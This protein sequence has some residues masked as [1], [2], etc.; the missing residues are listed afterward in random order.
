M[1]AAAGSVNTHAR[2]ISRATPQRTAEIRRV[3]P[4]PITDAV[5]TCVVDMGAAMTNAVR[6]STVDAVISATK[7]CTGR[8]GKIRRPSVRMIRQPP[9]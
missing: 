7:P 1:V 6:Y 5:I 9:E 2:P 8:N 4:T 3:L